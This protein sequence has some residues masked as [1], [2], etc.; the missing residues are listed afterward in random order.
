MGDREEGRNADEDMRAAAILTPS[1]VSR[2]SEM[3]LSLFQRRLL[4]AEQ[5]CHRTDI[6]RNSASTFSTVAHRRDTGNG[7]WAFLK[8]TVR[9][10]T[11]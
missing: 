2:R 9:Q 4:L 10:V 7:A 11:R 3:S 8:F 6:G 1:V 5:T